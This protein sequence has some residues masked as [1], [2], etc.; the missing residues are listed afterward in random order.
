MTLHLQLAEPFLQ[1][2]VEP[3][4]VGLGLGDQAVEAGD[5]LSLDLAV[6]EIGQLPVLAVDQGVER[7][8]D[9]PADRL[10]L[11][12]ALTGYLGQEGLEIGRPNR[13]CSTRP[14]LEVAVLGVVRGRGTSPSRKWWA[15]GYYR[16][17]SV[18][19]DEEPPVKGVTRAVLIEA[20][21]AEPAADALEVEELHPAQVGDPQHVLARP[22]RADARV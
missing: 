12:P 10:D 21:A 13:N 16:A 6:E 7:D 19:L 18:G 22:R 3:V 8:L 17:R 5:G 4:E 11:M 20:A 15:V 9:V 2:L 1:P 14:C